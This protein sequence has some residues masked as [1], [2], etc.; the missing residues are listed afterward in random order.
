M[1]RV[2]VYYRRDGNVI[3]QFDQHMV[4]NELNVSSENGIIRIETTDAKIIL[5]PLDLIRKIEMINCD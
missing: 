2:D 5:H 1:T 4:H 3:P